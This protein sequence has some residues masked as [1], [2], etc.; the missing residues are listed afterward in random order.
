[1]KKNYIIIGIVII[2]ICT[3]FYLT[4]FGKINVSGSTLEVTY[5]DVG[6]A[7]SILITQG[8]HSMLIDGGTN[9]ERKNVYKYIKEKGIN[10]L[11]YIIA[12]HP[13]KDHIGGLDYI[14]DKIEVDKI[15]MPQIEIDSNSYD[16]LMDA[17]D[18]N[19]VLKE[20]SKVN[21]NYS[22]GKANFTILA[23]NEKEYT[24]I[25][26]YSIV[27]KLD[28]Y[29]NSFIFEGDAQALSEME[30][31]EKKYDL[32]A[33]VLKIAHHGS[34]YAT[35]DDFL[36]AVNPQYAIISVGGNK[37]PS[38]DTLKRLENQGVKVFRTD[39]NS[40]ITCVSNGNE[41]TFLK[42]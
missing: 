30:M 35:C 9:E 23:P 32:N 25:N 41:L 39:I 29:N 33:D 6:K 1:M 8:N 38:E 17:I 34:E 36:K 21:N 24:E 13:H 5:I 4:K 42:D 22:L 28:F 2:I 31:V 3:Y 20:Y 16:D 7:D 26:N 40:D 18:D 15:I 11:D 14:I 37:V 19:N 10:K 27:I 12:T